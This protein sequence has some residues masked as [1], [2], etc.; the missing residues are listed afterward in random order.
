[1]L[2]VN[3]DCR[4][5]AV[6][7]AVCRQLGYS[8]AELMR[9]TI[10]HIVPEEIAPLLPGIVDNVRKQGA[11]IFES[12]HRRKDGSVMPVEVHNHLVDWE[13][14]ESCLTICRDLTER[15]RT[16]ES[17]RQSQK[18]E[19]IG[20]LAGGMAHEF[21]NI[22]AAM[23]MSLSLAKMANDEADQRSLLSDLEESCERSAGLIKQLLAFS[24]QSVLNQ[25]AIDLAD[26][27]KR[28][29]NSLRPLLGERIEWELAIPDG[30]PCARADKPLIE[31]VLLNLCLNARDAMPQGGRLRLEVG[32]ETVE[33]ERSKS[34]LEARAGQYL[35]LSVTD[36]GCGMDRRTLQRIFEPFFS[37]KDVGKGT[38]LGLATVRG[39][40]LQHQGWVEV[41]SH[42]GKGSVFRVYLPP[43]TPVK[44]DVP[45]VSLKTTA[46]SGNGTLLIVEDNE[47]LRKVTGQVLRQYGYRVLEAAEGSAAMALWAEHRDEIDLLYT[48][49]VMPGLLSGLQIAE[50]FRMEKPGIKVIITSGYNTDIMDIEKTTGASMIYLPKPCP[51]ET[52]LA[53]ITRCFGQKPGNP[54]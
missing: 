41:D 34:C 50:R 35:R 18:M 22:L 26:L 19:A 21:N 8:H 9:M 25:Q 28:Q 37:T 48:D 24:R 5:L 11:M 17:L 43:A 7:D 13:G 47:R 40:I 1:M 49:M 27:V 3:R 14:Q 20:H 38:G 10:H 46:V 30:L 32:L 53:A 12:A 16:E 39:I 44:L 52:L 23:M 29:V 33:A 2:V 31:Q 6:N 51:I 4:I 36:T 15:K 45:P 54:G 42:P